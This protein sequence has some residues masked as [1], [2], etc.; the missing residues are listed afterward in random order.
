MD[1]KAILSE[2]EK[3]LT[4][5]TEK[6]R[7]DLEELRK[8]LRELE[9]KFVEVAFVRKQ[10]DE[11]DQ[12]VAFTD[13]VAAKNFIELAKAVWMG[14]VMQAKQMSESVD[15]DGGYLVPEEFRASIIRLVETFGLARKLGTIIPMSRDELKIPAV[16]SGVRAYWVGEGQTIPETKPQFGQVNLV[17]KKLG[18]IVPVTSE[19]LEDASISIANLLASLF[20]EAMAE[21]ED[22][23]AFTG[24]T[25]AGDPFS[26]VLY[27]SGVNV[28]TMESGKTNF[29]DL[30]ADHLLDLTSAVPS[31]AANKGVFLMNRTV[32][33]VVRKL[34][35]NNGNYIWSPPSAKEPG[36]IWGYPYHLS[37]VMPGVSESGAN[38]PFVAFGDFRHL[39]IGDR[40]QLSL[41]QSQHVRF[42]EDQT[43]LRAIERVAFAVG[44]PRAFA[45][46]YTASS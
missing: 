23:V 2:I 8:E 19:L 42:Y 43:V 33:N 3:K 24:N 6:Q 39:Y 17:A 41:A 9:R 28:V 20:A 46:L 31:S 25:S 37:D 11:T 30:T 27:T 10:T 35:D 15:A 45:V 44:I 29:T 34:K 1:I 40:K 36:T 4:E 12:P 32:F 38:K 7:T 21:E 26:G 16:V 5:V 13:E 14:D 22:R 18:A